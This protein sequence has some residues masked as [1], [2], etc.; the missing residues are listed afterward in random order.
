M[1]QYGLPTRCEYMFRNF[2]CAVLYDTVGAKRKGA[3]GHLGAWCFHHLHQGFR[4]FTALYA[5]VY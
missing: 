4:T 1:Y 2:E 5:N 3:F